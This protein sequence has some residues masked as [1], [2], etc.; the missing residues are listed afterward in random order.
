MFHLTS[1]MSLNLTSG[2]HLKQ[3]CRIAND[4]NVTVSLVAKPNDPVTYLLINDKV[5]ESVAG[6]KGVNLEDK[7]FSDSWTF[8][9]T[10]VDQ[11]L[12]KIALLSDNER[13]RFQKKLADFYT[14]G[15]N[16]IE[17]VEEVEE[18]PYAGY[19]EILSRTSVQDFNLGSN[20]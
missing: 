12:K 16:N 10:E 20:I 7:T 2:S 8:G 5:K 15:N 3:I 6:K 13:A 19:Q 14:V 18:V 9:D 1:P 11:L 4:Y 17:E